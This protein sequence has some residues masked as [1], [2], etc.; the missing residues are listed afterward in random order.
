[1]GNM[2]KAELCL[3]LLNRDESTFNGAFFSKLP[4]SESHWQLHIPGMW[5]KH[6][7]RLQLISNLNAKSMIWYLLKTSRWTNL[8]I[9]IY[10]PVNSYRN[11]FMN[12][13]GRVYISCILNVDK[14]VHL[15]ISVNLMKIL[16]FTWKNWNHQFWK[17]TMPPL[18]HFINTCKTH[19]SSR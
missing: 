15:L 10:I 3:K 9:W 19:L 7:T 2:S 13:V 18:M 4:F 12:W 5:Y 6:Y 11:H 14:Q 16:A 8:E 1:M 17:V